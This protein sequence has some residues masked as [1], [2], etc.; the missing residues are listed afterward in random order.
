M[1]GDVEVR[2]VEQLA[3]LA[4]QLKAAGDK[5]LKRELSKG[6]AAATKPLKVAVKQSALETL[7]KKGGL[8]VRVAAQI[9]PRTRRSANGVRITATGKQGARNLADLDRGIVRHPVFGHRGRWSVE[10]VRPGFWT[11]PLEDLAPGAR[12][13]LLDAMQRVAGQITARP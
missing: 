1:S 7:P 12:Q 5:G 4:R 10:K 13:E 9:S 8:N 2:G 6:I 11:R 3:A